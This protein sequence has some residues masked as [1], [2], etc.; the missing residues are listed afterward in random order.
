MNLSSLPKQVTKSKKRIGRGYGSGRGGHAS[1][2]GAKGQNARG[3]VGLLFEGSKNK[4]S[5]IKRLPF[6]RGKSKFKVS[7]VKPYLV[8]LSQL[9]VFKT[10]EE[11]TLELLKQKKIIPQIIGNEKQVKILADSDL[12]V[13]LTILL[14]CSKSA[15]EKIQKAGG[16]TTKENAK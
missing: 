16:K 4:K 11:V 14:P 12:K 3:S 5:W 1:G 15:A 2:R 13:A 6:L 10:G 9:S 7:S 8:K